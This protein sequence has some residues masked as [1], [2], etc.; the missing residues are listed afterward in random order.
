MRFISDCQLPIADLKFKKPLHSKANGGNSE[1]EKLQLKF[2]ASSMRLSDQNENR[3]L[4][5]GNGQWLTTGS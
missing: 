4:A 3:Q 1:S 2:D 5:I